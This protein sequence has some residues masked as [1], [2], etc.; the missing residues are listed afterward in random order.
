MFEVQ[1]KTAKLKQLMLELR[2]QMRDLVSKM[3]SSTNK[4]RIAN[5]LRTLQVYKI[6]KWPWFPSW[7]LSTKAKSH[8][9]CVQT[10]DALIIR[11]VISINHYSAFI[12]S[13]GIDNSEK[14][15]VIS[16]LMMS[17]LWL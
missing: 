9:K 3:G 16:V 6:N 14:C 17:F 5:M 13:I 12:N 4:K 7:Y 10:C 15:V 11:S 2:V 8:K 1:K